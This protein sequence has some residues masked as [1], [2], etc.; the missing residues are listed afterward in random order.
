M[1]PDA[2]EGPSRGLVEEVIARREDCDSSR[3]HRDCRDYRAGD[4]QREER[5]I[6]DRS[7]SYKTA[8]AARS[9]TAN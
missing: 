1:T 7:F 3:D 4:L 6:A 2:R 9:V 5:L 8:D